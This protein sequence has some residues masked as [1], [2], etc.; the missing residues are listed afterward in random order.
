MSEP[1]FFSGLVQKHAPESVGP[2]GHHDGPEGRHYHCS[3]P[4][5]EQ[6]HATATH[7]ASHAAQET[8]DKRQPELKVAHRDLRSGRFAES[9]ERAAVDMGAQG[10]IAHLDLTTGPAAAQIAAGFTRP[11][12]IGGHE[13]DSPQNRGA[14]TTDGRA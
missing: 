1:R 12:M 2:S 10:E 3:V 9:I 14:G 6:E 8:A 5:C 11:L 7:A 13:L 4:G